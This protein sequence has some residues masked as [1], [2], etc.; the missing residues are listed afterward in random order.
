MVEQL[1]LVLT[2]IV[3]STVQFLPNLFYA[4]ILLVIGLVVGKIVGRIVKEIL[5]KAKVDYYVHETHK[6]PVNLSDLFSVIARW[7]I[8]LA[9]ITTALSAEILGLPTL[10]SWIEGIGAFIPNIIGAAVIVVVGYIIGEWI[11][12]QM[13]KTKRGYSIITGKILFFFILYVSVALALP[14]LGISAALV[15]SIMLTIIIAVGAAFAL[16]VGL[17]GRDVVNAILKKWA[18]KSRYM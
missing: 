9:F 13:S 4:I 7:W 6:P 11:K 18:R 1:S 2:N 10:S 14:I 8:Y 15:N 16:A 5:V 12:V 17:G 3:D